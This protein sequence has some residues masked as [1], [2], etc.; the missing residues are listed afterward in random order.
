[1]ST[2]ESSR[3]P[4][5]EPEQTTIS[6]RQ[7]TGVL[8]CFIVVA[9]YGKLDWLPILIPSAILIWYGIIRSLPK[10]QADGHD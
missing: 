7:W 9:I 4:D 1:M 6:K 5:L 10:P 3:Q 2:Q 8:V